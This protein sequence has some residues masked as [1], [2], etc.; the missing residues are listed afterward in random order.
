[1]RPEIF[2]VEPGAYPT[3]FVDQVARSATVG[4]HKDFSAA[5]KF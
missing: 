5:H 4:G 2:K 1:M 3:L